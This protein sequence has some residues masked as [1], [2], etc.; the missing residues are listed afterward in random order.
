MEFFT[1][2]SAPLALVTMQNFP[3]ICLLELVKKHGRYPLYP[4]GEE[5]VYYYI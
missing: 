5:T 2:K 3:L 1:K 4:T